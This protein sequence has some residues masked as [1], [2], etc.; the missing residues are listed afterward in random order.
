MSKD[1]E[2]VLILLISNDSDQERY[3]IEPRDCFMNDLMCIVGS[4]Y[5]IKRFG[6]CFYLLNKLPICPKAF[7]VLA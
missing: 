7:G 2:S 5:A 3:G 4:Y 1:G 6:C